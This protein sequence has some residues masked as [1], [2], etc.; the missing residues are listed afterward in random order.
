M[1]KAPRTLTPRGLHRFPGYKRATRGRVNDA[2]VVHIFRPHPCV[3]RV[4]TQVN[5]WTSLW[6]ERWTKK[7]PRTPCGRLREH[8]RNLTSRS[9]DREPQAK[10]PSRDD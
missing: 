5:L 8:V 3:H 7:G 1:G 2:R 6:V 4:F 10:D 9:T